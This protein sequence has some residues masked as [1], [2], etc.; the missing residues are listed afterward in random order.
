MQRETGTLA[1]RE[2]Y[3]QIAHSKLPPHSTSSIALEVM[4]D[5]ISSREKGHWR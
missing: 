1:K 4:P 3:L 2:R 5:S